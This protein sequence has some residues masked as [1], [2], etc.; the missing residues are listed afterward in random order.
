ME[1]VVQTSEQDW[2]ASRFLAHRFRLLANGI[3]IHDLEA[4]LARIGEWTDWCREWCSTA[5]E[6]ESRAAEASAGGH[7]K[8]AAQF[9]LRAASCY[10]F[11][12]N[13][14]YEDPEQKA[15][16]QERKI[17][18]FA[19][20]TLALAPSVERVLIP[21]DGVSMAANLRIHKDAA[22]APC[23]ILVPGSDASKEEFYPREQYYLDRGIAT[24]SMDGPGQGETW[25]V[26]RM[27][28][29]YEKAISAV[30]DF[31]EE[32]SEI[33]PARIGL[34][35]GS[36]AGY[37]VV[38]AAASDKRIRACVENCGPFEATYYRWDDLLRLR[39]FNHLWGTD[40]I[41][42][43][44][45]VAQE[46]TLA[47]LIDRVECPLLVIHGK[48]DPVTPYAEALKIYERAQCPKDLLLLEGGNHVCHNLHHVVRPL[49]ADWLQVHLER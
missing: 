48:E 5:A 46:I 4:T 12:Q 19:R 13:L 35:G 6:Y 7:E 40:S 28:V 34:W 1:L 47:G 9:Y 38:R 27:R 33:N 37:L 24:L 23:V 41:P 3:D 25:S 43:A 49:T 45:R 2:Y 29:D 44:D 8:T 11:A 36:F 20:S 18:V 30:V 16:A 32:R 42:E 26:M 14:F 22:G 21:F 15:R 39:R 10:H 31:L 17:E